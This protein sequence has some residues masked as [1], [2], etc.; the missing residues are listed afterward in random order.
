MACCGGSSAVVIRGEGDVVVSGSG[1]VADPYVVA[2]D[3]GL[4]ITA[5]A[6]STIAMRILGSGN[7]SD[8]YIISGDLVAG[9]GALQDVSIP[10]PPSSGEVLTWDGAK[11]VATAVSVDPGAINVGGGVQGD[12]TIGDPLAVK[13][14]NLVDT[15]LSGAYTYIDSSGEL[16]AQVVGAAWG[17]I[18]G[19]PSTFPPSAH[20]HTNAD[21]TGMLAGT[22]A[23]TGGLGN[24]GDWY[25]QYV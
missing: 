18:T 19:K 8:P 9:I 12:G 23:P 6:S 13:V 21:L 11:W 10:T 7:T 3:I 14:S 22:S 4:A 15:S 16:R 2:G 24:N 25:A 20:T 1:T 5:S 17:S